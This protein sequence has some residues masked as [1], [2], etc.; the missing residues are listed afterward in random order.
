MTPYVVRL[1]R[2]SR[3]SYRKMQENLVWATGYK[4]FVAARGERRRRYR[5]PYRVIRVR[6]RYPFLA[7]QS[8]R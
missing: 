5:R 4:V 1:L 6:G 2:L 8:R 3:T 7:V